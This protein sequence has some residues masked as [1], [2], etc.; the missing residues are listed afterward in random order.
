MDRISALILRV[1]VPS[2]ALAALLLGRS[3]ARAA[4]PEEVVIVVDVRPSAADT[5]ATV[6]SRIMRKA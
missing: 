1:F 6:T 2:T 5:E 3:Q 4:E